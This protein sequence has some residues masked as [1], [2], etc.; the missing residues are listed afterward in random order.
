MAKKILVVDDELGI[1]NL[2]RAVLE[3]EGY[4]VSV[5]SGGRQAVDAA[6]E[7]EPDLVILD[8]MM[9]DVTGEEV[10]QQMD[11][12]DELRSTPVV[13]MSAAVMPPTELET[14]RETVFLAKPFEIEQ[15][16]HIVNDLLT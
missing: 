12:Q 5:A 13:L 14:E 15:L 16:V 10:I 2:V 1:R 8:V 9:P 4:E 6:A 11:A 3:D 7:Q